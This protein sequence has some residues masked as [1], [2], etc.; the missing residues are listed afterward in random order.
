MHRPRVWR[1]TADN[2]RGWV[3]S[4]RAEI[5]TVGLL[6]SEA[7]LLL[8]FA[9]HHAVCD[10]TPGYAAAAEL[11][12]QRAEGDYAYY[13][14]IAAF[15]TGRPAPSATVRWIE[16]EETVRARWQQLVAARRAFAR[17]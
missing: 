16:D 11:L 13:A 1:F 14:D 5:R 10:G 9:S 12:E 17:P 15:M 8:A 4:L 6:A 7:M 2:I 3:D